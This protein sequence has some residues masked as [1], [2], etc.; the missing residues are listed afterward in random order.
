MHHFRQTWLDN[1]RS[2]LRCARALE[3]APR[4]EDEAAMRIVPGAASLVTGGRRA[5][6]AGGKGGASGRGPAVRGRSAMH[7]AAGPG[8]EMTGARDAERE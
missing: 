7:N 8:A 1:V 3:Q 5:P 4:H 6:H 2:E